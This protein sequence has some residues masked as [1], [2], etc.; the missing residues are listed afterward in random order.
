VV[1]YRAEDFLVDEI[2]GFDPDGEGPHTLL[3]IRKTGAN[4][5]W[6]ARRLARDAG[7][8]VRDVGYCGLKDRHA[9]ATQWFSVPGSPRLDLEGLAGDGIELLER[10]P[11]RRKLRRG[12]HQ[13]NR[14]RLRLRDLEGSSPDIEE[15]I[16]SIARG[17]VPNYFGEQRFGRKGANLGLARDL[18]A[19]TRL[20]RGKRAFALSA[21]RSAIFN[22]VLSRRI[23]EGT[24]NRIS[25]GD[26]AMLDG[27]A[28]RFPVARVDA[29]LEARAARLDLHPTGPL[30]GRGDP[31]SSG[32]ILALERAVV[33][34]F[35]DLSACVVG[36]NMDHDRRALRLAVR[37]FDW[38]VSDGELIV[39]FRLPRGSF[40]T[41][42][43]REL[44][45]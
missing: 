5:H 40:A 35:P 1:R 19:G 17:G 29:E 41:A 25:S 28:S 9:V 20:D 44:M 12:A 31:P 37:D 23:T 11:H 38:E 30:W 21:A 27:T 16:A 6:V 2:L 45:M 43:L 18:A 33:E 13:G 36:A 39:G 15:R 24:W 22:Q 3:R 4:S 26:L 10:T 8:P 32:E 7:V 34:A 14:F 42:V